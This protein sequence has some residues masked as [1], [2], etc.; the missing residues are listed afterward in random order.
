MLGAQPAPV[1]DRDIAPLGD[2]DQR[3]MRLEI[4]ARGEIGLVGRDE[5]QVELVG[6][7]E[8]LRLD[9]AL[10][11]QA[12]ALELDIEPVAE[13]R[14]QRLEPRAGKLGDCRRRARGR[15]ARRGRR[16]ARSGLRPAPRA[17]R[18]AV[19]TSPVSLAAK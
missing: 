3:V 10:L 15:P 17:R 9:R 6:E 11:R 19:T 12:V 7:L 14:V 5:R 2:A 18:C 13:D 1:V 16:S 4:V 8:Q